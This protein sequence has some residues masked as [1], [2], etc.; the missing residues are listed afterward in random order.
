MLLFD[1]KGGRPEINTKARPLRKR[2][3]VV[4]KNVEA[5]GV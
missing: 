4:E 1:E 2:E 5:I 3:S